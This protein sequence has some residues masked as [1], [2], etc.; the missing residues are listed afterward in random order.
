MIELLKNRRSVRTFLDKPVEKKLIDKLLQ[1]AL[2]GPSAKDTRPWEFIVVEEPSKLAKLSECKP[3]DAAFLKES[4][5]AIVIVADP[6]KSLAWIEDAAISATYMQL[7]AEKE[8]LGSCWV[9]IRDRMYNEN[10][11]SGQYVKE[12]L[13][14]PDK[15][16]V[17]CVIGFGHK[18][19][20][21][22]PHHEGHIRYDQVHYGMF[23]ED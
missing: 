5:L 21:R 10:T 2:L 4:P 11:S 3:E 14:I 17:A 18:E 19:N 7:V 15:Y 6:E 16:E 23:K 20:I 1:A 12:L 13:N 22:P 8:H 9:Q